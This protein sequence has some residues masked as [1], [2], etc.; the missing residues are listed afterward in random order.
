M[1][2]YSL[3]GENGPRPKVY[4]ARA[5]DLNP[6]S[7]S[8]KTRFRP[9]LAT[10]EGDNGQVDIFS[11]QI[12]W[13][14]TLLKIHSTRSECVRDPA[15][16]NRRQDLRSHTQEQ[17][18]TTH[19]DRMR[20]GCYLVDRAQPKAPVLL[21]LDQPE[22]LPAMDEWRCPLRIQG[23]PPRIRSLAV[24]FPQP[25]YRDDAQNARPPTRLRRISL[26]FAQSP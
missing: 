17:L 5:R 8:I 9:R 7:C 6:D 18:K 25:G 1:V 12:Q 23:S 2:E 22:E 10:R 3:L 4:P 21:R 20:F 16:G 13:T 15:P 19:P 24:A 26:R 14:A 11:P